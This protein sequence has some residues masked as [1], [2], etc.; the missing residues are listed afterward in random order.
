[1]TR[2]DLLTY[3]YYVLK[4]LLTEAGLSASDTSEGL[5]YALDSTFRKL[6]TAEASLSS[7]TTDSV[8]AAQVLGE[9]YTLLRIRS[10]LAARVD[11]DAT[12]IETGSR[13]AIFDQVNALIEDA[14][15][16]CESIGYPV[17]GDSASSSAYGLTSLYVDYNE[18]EPTA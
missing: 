12:A 11:F 13:S 15:M 5:K 4:D 2:S 3:L 14:V 1:M 6:G 16:R 10:V 7:A 9:Y 18:P 17:S 8:A